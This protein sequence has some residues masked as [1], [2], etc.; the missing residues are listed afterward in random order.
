MH[1]PFDRTAIQVFL[2]SLTSCAN[3]KKLDKLTKLEYITRHFSRAEK[4][5]FEHYVVT[6]IWHQLDDLSIKFVTQQCVTRPGG[7]A[8]TDMFFPQ[9]ETHIEIDEP[10]HFK[11]QELDKLRELDIINATNHSILRIDVNTTI[12]S[13]NR[14]ISDIVNLLKAKK[15]Q[16]S[17]FEPWDL[18]K[19]Q[20]PRTYINKGFMDVKDDVAFKWSYLAANCFGHSYKGLQK[21]ASMHPHE[22]STI[23]WFPKLYPNG[24]WN[25]SISDDETVITEIC[26]FDE[27]AKEHID[28]VIKEKIHTRIVFARVKSP[29]G[30]VMYRFKGRYELDKENSSYTKRLKWRKTSDRVKTYESGSL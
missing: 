25:N 15:K 13:V 11:Q 20:N 27:K 21:G 18:K 9:L 22:D 1:C 10:H 5:R 16:L 7:I 14:Q 4:K 23:I 3:A 19:E 26:K 6:R 29:L 12:H 2:S 24:T 30:D 28:L 8:L 17:K